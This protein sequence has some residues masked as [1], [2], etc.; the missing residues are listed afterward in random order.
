MK[1]AKFTSVI[2]TFTLV[3]FMS[4]A[5]I[6]NTATFNTGDL[7]R[8]GEKSL[9][10]SVTYE[11]D[12]SYLRFDATKFKNENEEADAIVSY[13]D[14]LRFDVND[15][16]RENDSDLTELPVANQFEHLRFDVN[17]FSESNPDAITELPVNEFDYLRFNANDFISL[18]NGVIDELPVTE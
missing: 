18:N 10:I 17:S 15:F 14:Y 11:K 4:L 2:A 1:T 6:A 16:M 8:S 5:S 13:L 3:M 9:A 7:P 12:Y